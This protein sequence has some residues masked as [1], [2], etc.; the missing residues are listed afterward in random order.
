MTQQLVRGRVPLLFNAVTDP[1]AAG[2]LPPGQASAN[3]AGV[4]NSVPL[5]DQFR[6]LKRTLAVKRVGVLFNPMKRILSSSWS[7]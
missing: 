7:D 2:I 6:L 3:I 4:S 5:A 1:I